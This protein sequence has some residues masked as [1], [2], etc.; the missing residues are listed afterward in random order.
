MTR[1]PTAFDLKADDVSHVRPGEAPLPDAAVIVEEAAETE[2]LPVPLPSARRRFPWSR[3]FFG[4][5]A[6]ILSL[7]IGLWL[8]Q[9]VRELFA[10]DDWLGWLAIGLIALAVLAVVAIAA[11]EI[12]GL[13]WLRRIDRMR[14]RADLAAVRDDRPEAEAVVGELMTLYADRPDL[15]PGRRATEARV[16]DVIDGRDRLVLAE[17][18]LLAPLDA[19][20]R[21]LVSD[22]AAR[23]SVVTAVSPRA[24][25]DVIFVVVATLGLIR[26][27]AA[28]YGGRPGFIGLARLTRLVLTHL[29]VTGSIAIGDGLAQQLIGHGLAAKLSARLGEGVINGLLTARVGVAAIDVCR[30][31]PFLER[32][33]PQLSE[34]MAGIRAPR[35][36]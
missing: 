17:A 16:H 25:I 29:A 19:A 9:L 2:D 11:R 4:A 6:G 34:I 13:I 14:K 27:L 5:V 32:R 26:R 30:P 15:A 7:A 1:R 12:A 20:A 21:R 23:V 33:R 35:A 28:L 22:A 31:L 18:D 36:K 10:R 24:A 8:D 3:L